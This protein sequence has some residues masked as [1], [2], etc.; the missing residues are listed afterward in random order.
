MKLNIV[1]GRSGTGK[2]EYIY[3][4]ISKKI[5]KNKIFLIVP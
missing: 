2:S 1:Y 5:G 3:E 4:D